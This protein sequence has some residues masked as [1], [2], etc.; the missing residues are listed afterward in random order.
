MMEIARPQISAAAPH[1]DLKWIGKSVRRVEDPRYLRG[2]G[3]Y[4]DDLVFPGMLHGRTIRSTI[5]RGRI[6]SIR[7]DFD[8]T[9]FTVVEAP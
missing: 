2:L 7:L 1:R 5:A 3:T 4:V 9:G 8:T 6:R